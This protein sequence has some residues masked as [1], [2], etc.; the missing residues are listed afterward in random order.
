MFAKTWP[1]TAIFAGKIKKPQIHKR[2]I[3]IVLKVAQ[4]I[5]YAFTKNFLIQKIIKKN[6]RNV[7]KK[8]ITSLLLLSRF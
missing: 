7:I 3:F 2:S 1:D 6:Y 4:T 8:F 5:N